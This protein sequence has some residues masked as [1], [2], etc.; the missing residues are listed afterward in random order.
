[1]PRSQDHNARSA[2][3]RSPADPQPLLAGRRAT[4]HD[5][6]STAGVSVSAVSKVVRNAYGVSPEL[7][8][9]VTDAIEQLGY[10][11]N[12]GARALRG[13]SYTIGVVLVDLMSPFQPEVAQ[14]ITDELEHTPYQDVVVT[15][16]LAP[17]R[18]QRRIEALMDRQVA[19]LVL[20]APTLEVTW[21]EDLAKAVPI[22]TVAL[23]GAAKNF[24]TVVHDQVLGAR[25]VVDYLVSAGHRRIVHTSMP[26]STADDS[27]VLSHTA[28]RYAFEES[29]REHGLEPSV[30]ET[31]YSEGGGYQAALE[32]FDRGEPPTAIFAGADI[33]ALGVL[34]AAE[35][36]GILVPQEL[37]V[38]G[39]DNI[40]MSMINRVSLTTV[41][42]SGHHTG[43]ASVRLLLERINGRTE[44]QQ[45]V[46]TPELIVRGTSG[47]PPSDTEVDIIKR[48]RTVSRDASATPR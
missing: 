29:M 24:D 38:V 26:A 46:L 1:M 32:A 48:R 18:Q 13:R 30:I 3:T 20:V 25:L 27:F 8:S 15:A 19:G 2:P 16:G 43:E 23:H 6:A 41:D 40:Y 35:E 4:L 36:R 10:R 47:P 28:R 21:I 39:Y 42:Q 12:A 31:S 5:V 11:P 44:P 45:V 7:R 14:G 37:T 33:A 34:R 17:E 22:I 9:R